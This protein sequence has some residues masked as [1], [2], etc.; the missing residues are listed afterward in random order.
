MDKPGQTVTDDFD[1]KNCTAPAVV[2]IAASAAADEKGVTTV[3]SQNING[4]FTVGGSKGNVAEA[5]GIWVQDNYPGTVR[6]AN[7][8]NVKVDTAGNYYNTSGIYL[9]GVDISRDPDYGS[10]KEPPYNKPDESRAANN[11]Y[12]NT[13]NG[14]ISPTSVHVGDQTTI[15]V[16]ANAPEGKSGDFLNAVA[17]ENHFGHMIVGNNVTVS[18]ETEV[19]K[20]NNSNGFAQLF[21][22]DTSIGNY[23]SAT[24]K[25]VADADTQV[26]RNYALYSRHDHQND[27]SNM[28]A[29]TQ[30]RLVLGD[31]AHLVSSVKVAAKNDSKQEVANG[32]AYLSRTD[33]SIGKGMMVTVSQDG[34]DKVSEVTAPSS[35]SYVVGLYTR[36]AGSSQ[37]PSRIGEGLRNEVIVN[38]RELNF[39]DGFHVSGWN[40]TYGEKPDL[41]D[42]SHIEVGEGSYT[43]I[44]SYDSSAVDINGIGLNSDS[45]LTLKKDGE[46]SIRKERGY[47]FNI[48][49]IYLLDQ[50]A[51]NL[52]KDEKVYIIQNGGKSSNIYGMDAYDGSMISAADGLQFIIDSTGDAEK[53][54][55]FGIYNYLKS[56]LTVGD[57]STVSVAVTNTSKETKSS[58]VSGIRNI[59]ADS[60]FGDDFHVQVQAV[61]YENAEGI[62]N[63]GVDL[64]SGNQKNGAPANM[65]IGDNLSVT[66]KAS[67]LS[68][69]G[70]PI[71]EGIRN[72]TNHLAG[73]TFTDGKNTMLTVG[74][75]AHISVTAPDKVKDVSALHSFNHANAEIGDGAVLTV[76]SHARNSSGR[77]INNVVKADDAGHVTFAGGMTLVGSQNAIYST[78]DGSSVTAMGAGRKVILG[79]LESADK[80]SIKLNLNTAD[81]LLRGKSTIDGFQPDAAMTHGLMAATAEVHD[82]SGNASGG[83]M[84][85]DTELTLANGARWDMT[86]SS[87]VTGLDHANGGLVNMQYNPEYQ[88]LDVGT[89]SGQNGIFRMKTDLDSETNGDKVYMNGAAAG[90]QGLVQVHDK[91]F[92]LGKEVTGTKHLLLITDNSRKATFSGQSIDEGGLWDVTPSI[93]NGKYVREVMGDADAKDTEWYL[94]KLTKSVNA[95]T[96]PLLGAVDYGYGLYRN[97]IDTLRQRMG[98]LRFLKNKRDAAGIWARTYG[99]NIDGPHYDSKYHAIQV[100][101]DYA[102][103]DKSIY[104]FLGERGI[105]SPHYD[106]GSSKDHSLA[107]AI[108]GTWFG[109]SGSYT[110]VVAKWGRDDSNL[111]TY[112]P[113]ADSANFRT[114]S[115]SL[116]LEYGKTTKLNGHGLFIEPQAQ[117]VLGRLNDKDFTTARGKIVHLGSYDS[118]I[119]RLGFVFGQRRPDAARPYDYYLKASVL[120]E[121]GGDRSFHLAAPDGET[122]DLTNH[123]G[124]TWYEAGFGGTYRVNNSTYLYADAERS[125]GSDW[126]KKWQAN[127][128]INWQF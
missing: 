66:V 14:H 127:V 60:F 8:L 49:G 64:N 81:S 112:G 128:G 126:H 99:G 61:N 90:S 2:D 115:E 119:G 107:G 17:L 65:T 44:Q 82:A 1:V 33:F 84:L 97:S 70:A 43:G 120:H 101:Y 111:H 75:N 41:K 12:T 103:N 87:Q 102:A 96:K 38:K 77:I 62:R 69:G 83:N 109:D 51:M 118:A 36:G 57:D 113:Y 116:S 78:G 40:E 125:F 52:E 24:M 108:Y 58:V 106:Y 31:D 7:G 68:N 94:T 114:S 122:M 88:R 13:Y 29:L 59:L 74:K 105:A 27:D 100:G 26:S 25:A 6:L 89:Y 71:V 55:T 124:S 19:F 9:E 42:S 91:S 5:N 3:N 11:E 86:A 95:D 76:N 18:T 79:D 121:F 67:D 10:D 37:N 28:Q 93:Q 123:Y 54:N 73:Y 92:L 46:I 32:G 23:F 98:D 104:G 35:A 85:A 34:V 47:A 20:E 50:S 30:N 48:H 45:A 72:G 39:I 56:N 80:G 53:S 4:T 63:T 15:T 117:L 110:D 21:Y 16:D 22:G